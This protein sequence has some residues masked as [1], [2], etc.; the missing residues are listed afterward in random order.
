MIKSYQSS[1]AKDLKDEFIE[2]NIKQG[3]RIK[4]RKMSI[5]IFSIKFADVSRLLLLIYLNR[6]SDVEQPKFRRYYLSK[7][8]I[9]NDGV[10]VNEKIL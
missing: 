10:I 9:K 4:I 8:I 6:E 5:D 3:V 2:I 7:G 1:S